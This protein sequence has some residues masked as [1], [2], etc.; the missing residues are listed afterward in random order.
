MVEVRYAH[1]IGRDAVTTEL[2]AESENLIIKVM[3][4]ALAEPK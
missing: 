4:L 1:Q 2:V 3:A